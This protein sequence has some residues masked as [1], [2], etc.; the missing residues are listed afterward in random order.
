MEVSRDESS[1]R[2]Q[3]RTRCHERTPMPSSARRTLVVAASLFAFGGAPLGAQATPLASWN[4]GPAKQAIMT[5]VRTT[6]DRSSPQYVAPDD[7]IAT[8]DNDGT[9]WVEHP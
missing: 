3:S 5:F 6:T 2:F 9:L 7:R 8:F 1:V 4:D